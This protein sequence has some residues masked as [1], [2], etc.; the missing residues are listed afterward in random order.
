VNSLATLRFA[1][2]ASV[3]GAVASVIALGIAAVGLGR[4]IARAS[5][6]DA[7]REF[8]LIYKSALH[9]V[10]TMVLVGSLG[11]LLISP[12]ASDDAARLAVLLPVL[13]ALLLLISFFY[14]QNR[15]LLRNTILESIRS[16]VERTRSQGSVC[17][18][19]KFDIDILVAINDY[20]VAVGSSIFELTQE[21]IKNAVSRLRQ[22]RIEVSAI[23]LP[24]SDEV[25]LVLPNVEIEEAADV[26]DRV[27]RE[28]KAGLPEIP[29]YREACA[30]VIESLRDPP[31]SAEER[32]GIGTVSAGVAAYSRGAEALLSDISASVK[33]SKFRGRNKTII[34]QPRMDSI[35]RSDYKAESSET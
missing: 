20:S 18:A 9:Y 17:S 14:R 24:E 1:D 7:V 29:H 23:S 25:I 26:A 34:Y 13:A 3:V 33:E 16:T 28:V 35:V 32:E 11:Y 31:L 10:L 12:P 27:R 19:I 6:G 15:R 5:P 2:W 4:Q 30:H 21:S 22:K 8:L